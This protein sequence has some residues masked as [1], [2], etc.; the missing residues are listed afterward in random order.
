MLY[1]C[2]RDGTKAQAKSHQ[3]ITGQKR[4]IINDTRKLGNFCVARMTATE[5]LEN[6]KVNVVYISSHCN[7]VPGIEECKYLPLP[8]SV[9][10]H[11]QQQFVAGVSLERII[12]GKITNFIPIYYNNHDVYRNKGQY[13]LQTKPR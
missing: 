3:N 12:D 11:I 4:K 10:K 7:H 8:P 2:C 9:K 6:G 13:R 1:V 5:N